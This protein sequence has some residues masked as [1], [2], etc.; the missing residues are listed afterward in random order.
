MG[1]LYLN[2]IMFVRARSPGRFAIAYHEVKQQ[3]EDV[4]M[5]SMFLVLNANPLIHSALLNYTVL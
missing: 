3:M 5:Y 2:Q 1:N 4:L